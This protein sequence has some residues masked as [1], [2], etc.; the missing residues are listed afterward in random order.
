MRGLAALATFTAV[1]IIT[2]GRLDSLPSLRAIVPDRRRIAA[3]LAAAPIGAAAAYGAFGLK[4]LGAAAAVLSG[5][6][7]AS[8]GAARLRRK[9]TALAGEW[10]DVILTIRS[11]LATGA[12]LPAAVAAAFAEASD[13]IRR[14]GERL[15][16]AAPFAVALAELRTELGDPAADRV[17]TA[18]TV[19][20][21]AGGPRVAEILARLGDSVSAELRLRSAHDAAMIEQRLTAVAALAAPW[22]LLSLTLLT[23]PAAAEAFRTPPG[24]VV[25]VV[26]LAGTL[27]GHVL[28]GRLARLSATPRLMT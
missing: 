13:P 1:W 10:V 4:S 26:G 8:M 14:C 28:A 12:P 9:Q 2:S 7:A 18:L 24:T 5:L 3:S 21:D 20:H 16:G 11:L 27:V 17:L 25:I 22:M 6:G 15:A 23:N 19:A